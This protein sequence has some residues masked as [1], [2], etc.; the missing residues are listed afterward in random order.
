MAFWGPQVWA[1]ME[2]PFSLGKVITDST[3]IVVLR[4]EKIDREK[5]SIIY[6]KV[7]DLKGKQPGEV[8]KHSIGQAGFHPREWQKCDGVGGGR[9]DCGDVS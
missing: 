1:Y 7:S 9:S 2:V 5:N 8:V 6:A 4:V 3:N